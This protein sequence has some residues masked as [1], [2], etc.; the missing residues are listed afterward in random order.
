[1]WTSYTLKQP[2]LITSSLLWRLDPRLEKNQ[3]SLCDR[4]S[5]GIDD[6]SN[7]LPFFPFGKNNLSCRRKLKILSCLVVFEKPIL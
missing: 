1:M 4:L 6:S 7:L 5:N 2:Q 3:K